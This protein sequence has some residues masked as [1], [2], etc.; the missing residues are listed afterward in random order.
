MVGGGIVDLNMKSI[1]R[2]DKVVNGNDSL[3][4]NCPVGV[5][6]NCGASNMFLASSRMGR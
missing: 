6:C 5:F 2:G 3:F 4:L 1:R